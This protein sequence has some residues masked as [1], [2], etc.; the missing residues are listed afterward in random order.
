MDKKTPVSDITF[1]AF[2][3]ETTGLYA[4]QDSI[5]ELGAVKFRNQTVL[6]S[7]EQ[8]EA[9]LKQL[10]GEK[11]GAV[12]QTDKEEGKKR[13]VYSLNKSSG[14]L[15]VRARPSQMRMVGSSYP[16]PEASSR[17]SGER[18]MADSPLSR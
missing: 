15:F 1:V 8:L 13:T 6:E 2:D 9:N 14:T 4:G 18:A 17:P 16:D 5:V 12:K 3:F 10:I 11:E 7:Y